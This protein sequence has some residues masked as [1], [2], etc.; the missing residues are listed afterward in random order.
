MAVPLTREQTPVKVSINGQIAEVRRELALRAQV[1]PKRV[2][3]GKMKQSEADLCMDRMR[4]VLATLDFMAA[5]RETILKATAADRGTIPGKSFLPCFVTEAQAFAIGDL[6][7]EK[8][9]PIPDAVALVVGLGLAALK[10]ERGM[11]RIIETG[12]LDG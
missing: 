6:A 7:C 9:M 8:S 12:G 3:D 1:F 5:H 2:R 10:D 11:A 4:A